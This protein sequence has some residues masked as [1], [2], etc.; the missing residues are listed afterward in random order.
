MFSNA[1]FKTFPFWFNF[2]LNIAKRSEFQIYS[3]FFLNKSLISKANPRLHWKI[4]QTES[5]LFDSGFHPKKSQNPSIC[6]TSYTGQNV[7]GTARKKKWKENCFR[8]RKKPWL[9]RV[10]FL[11]FRFFPIIAKSVRD[12]VNS[13]KQQNIHGYETKIDFVL[14]AQIWQSFKNFIC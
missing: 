4:Y 14:F 7:C 3:R 10:N 2:I 13:G 1:F 5:K 12:V 8:E 9:I 6:D 11:E